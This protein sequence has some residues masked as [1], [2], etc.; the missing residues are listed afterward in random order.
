M[1]AKFAKA[2]DKDIKV[3]RIQLNK[4]ITVPPMSTIQCTVKLENDFDTDVCFQPFP[5]LKGITIPYVVVPNKAEIPVVF[6]N[7]TNEF[8]SL[9]KGSDLGVGIEVEETINTE[10]DDIE[11]T[12]ADRNEVQIRQLNQTETEEPC[13]VPSHLT[14][15]LERSKKHLSKEQEIQLTK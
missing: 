3:S 8:I 11:E 15:L 5:D 7:A 4:R 10:C 13:D 1:V 12:T 6:N 14:D 9:K 2:G